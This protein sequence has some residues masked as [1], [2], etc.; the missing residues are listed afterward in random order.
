[1]ACQRH[2][3]ER[4]EQCVR[5]AR[6]ADAEPA[7]LAMLEA[8]LATRAD[9]MDLA[10]RLLAQSAGSSL[11]SFGALGFGAAAAFRA[12]EVD[13][14]IELFRRPLVVDASPVIMRLEE[15][16][17]P[18]LDLEAFAPRRASF[19]LVWPVEA[20]M[21]DRARLRLFRSVRIESGTPEGSD[22]LAP[23]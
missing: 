6:E 15:Q 7:N 13:R 4:L 5:D 9:R 21:I 22:V 2:E 20:P 23:Q 17:H 18:L 19:D 8:Y 14:A 12:G 3:F 11:L 16:L 10:K 1:M